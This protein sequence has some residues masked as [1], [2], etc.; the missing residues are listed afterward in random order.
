MSHFTPG[1]L[2]TAADL[3]D[4]VRMVE[5]TVDQSKASG[6]S[7]ANDP[8]LSL[9]VEAGAIYKY[10]LVAF[11]TGGDNAGDI[12]FGWSI[13]SG[14]AINGISQNPVH[15]IT[16]GTIGSGEWL[17]RLGN[18]TFPAATGVFSA[19]GHCIKGRLSV[20]GTAGNITVQW[21][22]NSSNATAT[23]L[24]AGSH[25]TLWRVG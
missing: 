15:T 20:G 5:K 25:L 6:A 24:K 11:S 13:P 16:T 9:P 8:E 7:P 4:I 22:Q 3:N 12:R 17:G 23:V 2:L 14:S 1:Q 21:S 10:E 18:S 19:M